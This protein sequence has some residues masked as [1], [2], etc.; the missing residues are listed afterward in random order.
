MVHGHAAKKRR[1]FPLIDNL[2]ATEKIPLQ[3]DLLLSED[4]RMI[5]LL[6]P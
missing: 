6:R 4:G 2:D 1:S 5:Q 3:S